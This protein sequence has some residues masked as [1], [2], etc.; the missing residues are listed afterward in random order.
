VLGSITG[1]TG[2]PTIEAPL[3]RAREDPAR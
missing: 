1:D 3:A 2:P